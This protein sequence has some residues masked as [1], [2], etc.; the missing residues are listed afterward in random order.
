MFTAR[1]CE[2]IWLNFAFLFAAPSSPLIS[3]TAPSSAASTSAPSIIRAGWKPTR[4]SSSAPRKKP[5]PLIAFFEP[6]RMLT[7]LYSRPCVSPATS[8]TALLELI[9]V[10]SL[11]MPES[12]WAAIT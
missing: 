4:L 11:A 7:H 12:A 10:R 6:V 3:A 9:L 1:F 2:K 8:L 5:T